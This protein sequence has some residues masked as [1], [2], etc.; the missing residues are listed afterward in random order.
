[1]NWNAYKKALELFKE[2]KGKEKW[3]QSS[4]IEIQKQ[5]TAFKSLLCYARSQVD[6]GGSS[7]ESLKKRIEAEITE[8]NTIG[9]DYKN[10]WKND[11][12]L[13]SSLQ[14]EKTKKLVDLFISK[15]NKK[16]FHDESWLELKEVMTLLNSEAGGISRSVIDQAENQPIEDDRGDTDLYQ[17][18]EEMKEGASIFAWS[19]LES[20]VDELKKFHSHLQC[21]ESINSTESEKLESKMFLRDIDSLNSMTSWQQ[22]TVGTLTKHLN[23]IDELVSSVQDVQKQNLLIIVNFTTELFKEGTGDKESIIE[24]KLQSVRPKYEIMRKLTDVSG[25][26]RQCLQE[27]QWWHL[28]TKLAR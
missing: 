18:L 17:W 11:S 13:Q 7:S 21:V 25:L 9:F 26:E 8:L 3:C 2:Y 12:L 19:S 4:L 5:S 24:S 6:A 10:M 23:D 14:T 28:F 22:E 20:V 27:M 16:A 15:K 1:M